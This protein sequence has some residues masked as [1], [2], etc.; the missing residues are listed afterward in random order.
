MSSVRGI[1]FE[2]A[3]RRPH[4]DRHNIW[5]LVVHAAYWKYRVCA[6]LTNLPRGSFTLKGSN[7]FPRPIDRSD[8]AL[9]ADL[10]LLSEWHVRLRSAVVAFDPE[11]LEERVG[12]GAHT[13]EAL[14][15]GI[16]AHDV[17]HAGQIQ[18]LK[19]L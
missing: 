6:R 19:K 10:Q 11:R 17:Y 8:A 15:E 13:Y 7:F 9:A 3:A 18:L 1:T 16:A 14:I 12:N 2:E 4:P 5:E